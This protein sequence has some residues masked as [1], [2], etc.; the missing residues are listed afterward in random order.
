[1]LEYLPV[2]VY[3]SQAGFMK[4]RAEIFQQALAMLDVP[5]GAAV[6]VGDRLLVD[7]GGA[8]AAGMRGVLIEVDHRREQ[9]DEVQAA[10][11]LPIIDELPALIA[12]WQRESS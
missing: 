1:M 10:A 7:V 12:R 9:S 6:Y 3:S 11:R 2:R 5:A 8:Q 4:P